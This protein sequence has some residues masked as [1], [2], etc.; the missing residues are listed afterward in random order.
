MPFGDSVRV[1]LLTKAIAIGLLT[2]LLAVTAVAT[3]VVV[4]HRPSERAYLHY[5]HT[6]G[7][8]GGP[9][10]PTVLT[11][12]R[13]DLLAAGARACGWLRDQPPALWRDDPELRINNLYVRYRREMDDADRALPEAFLPGAFTYLC[14][15][16]SYLRKPHLAVLRRGPDTG[17]T[18]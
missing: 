17:G 4:T 15:L 13:R 10:D 2:L 8:Y 1:R 7:D 5:V 16:S 9:D 3:A 6:Y 14:P 18:D 11:A 12:T